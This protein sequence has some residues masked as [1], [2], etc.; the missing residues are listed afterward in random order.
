MNLFLVFDTETTNLPLWTQPSGDPGQPHIV[1]LAASLV[2]YDTRE[3][4]SSVHLL[5]KPDGWAISQEVI[6]VHGITNEH[7]EL[8]GVSEEMILHI[9]LALWL[10]ASFRVAHEQSF[11]ARI[12]RIALKR[13][14][15]PEDF[16]ETFKAAPSR[17]TCVESTAMC[18]IKKKD[19]KGIKKPK[20]SEAYKHVTGKELEGAH[21]ATVDTAACLEVFWA[22]E[23]FNAKKKE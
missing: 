15:Y 17:C 2:N 14:G 19:G 23:A 5:A 20:L 18:Q 11:D 4:V 22:L 16:I 1:E 7:A 3:I 21:R 9:F 12:I 13:F 6:D 8:V 10:R